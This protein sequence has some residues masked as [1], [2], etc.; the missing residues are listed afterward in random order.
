MSELIESPRNEITI[1]FS[2]LTVEE[3]DE[4]ETFL[5]AQPEVQDVRRRYQVRD[6]APDQD[7]LGL[8]TH[9][10]YH[11]ALDL[12]KGVARSVAANAI[13]ERLKA[14]F[15]SKAPAQTKPHHQEDKVD[16][17]YEWTLR[18]E[19]QILRSVKRPVSDD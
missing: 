8:I 10:V 3:R 5:R 13:L 17:E 15:P 9:V 7:T 4:L 19:G 6:H 11:F 18:W 2:G 12:A 16:Q 1:E 14:R